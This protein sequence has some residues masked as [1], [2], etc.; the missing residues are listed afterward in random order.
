MAPPS[1]ATLAAAPEEQLGLGWGTWGQR[2]R[3]WAEVHATQNARVT[4]ANKL[5]GNLSNFQLA[6]S[7]T[8]PSVTGS[9]VAFS[10]RMHASAWARLAVGGQPREWT[11][12]LQMSAPLLPWPRLTSHG[13]RL[14]MM[15]ARG[16]SRRRVSGCRATSAAWQPNRRGSRLPHHIR[17]T[18]WG[19]VGGRNAPL[20][21]K[22][23]KT[24][25]AINH[26]NF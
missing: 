21:R 2:A 10:A 4:S 16:A 23:R 17:G 12:E 11:L 13:S 7:A 15:D 8:L 20:H 26:G 19:N 14:A 5:D 25:D 3:C 22:L 1:I 6:N 24:H 9:A 18:A